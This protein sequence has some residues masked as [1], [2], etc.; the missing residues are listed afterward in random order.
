MKTGRYT[1]EHAHRAASPMSSARTDED[2][3]AILPIGIPT[4]YRWRNRYPVFAE[5]SAGKADADKRVEFAL[6]QRAIG[7]E[8]QV[9]RAS[10]PVGAEKPVI[11]RYKRHVAADPCAAQL[12]AYPPPRSLKYR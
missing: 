10:M 9:E 5:A 2:V 1:P 12:A 7:Y 6:Y 4:L 3:V 8:Y 11:A